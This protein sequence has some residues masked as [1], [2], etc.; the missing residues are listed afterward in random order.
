MCSENGEEAVEQ[1]PPAVRMMTDSF[2]HQLP[3]D[4]VKEAADIDI[5]PQS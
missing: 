4:A 5:E 3:I 2:E 1:R